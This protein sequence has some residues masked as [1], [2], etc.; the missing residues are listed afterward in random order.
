[1]ARSRSRG[2]TLIELLV[3]IAIIAVLIGLLLPA[4]QKVREAASRAKCSNNLKQMGLAVHH[5]HDV[6]G[7]LP[8][9]DLGDNWPTWA[10]L[11]MPHLEQENV[12]RNWNLGARYYNQVPEAGADLA[13]Y[14]CPSRS[15]PG[16]AAAGG[17]AGETRAVGT[18][19]RTGPIG[20][21]DYA[22]S[23]GATNGGGVATN[24][25]GAGYRAFYLDRSAYL[26][27]SQ[28][29]MFEV[30][31]GWRYVLKFRDVTDGLSGTYLIGE[32]FYLRTSNGGVI[33]NGDYQSQ[34][35]RWA[36]RE[37]TQDPATGRW[38]TERGLV[39]DRDYAASDWNVRFSAANHLGV[40][41]FVFLDG[42]VAPVRAAADLE[43]VHRQAK[44]N[45]G[46]VTPNP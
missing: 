6:H 14:H 9:C 44:R 5:F 41:M 38:T 1:M 26:N 40:G 33:Y 8:A 28:T 30:W 36:G 3:V 43:V 19:T 29:D 21:G 37:G 20:W 22:M 10:V 46:L 27:S 4:V 25:D 11:L 12:Y 45:D 7:A 34:Y 24:W 13:V 18:V 32:K 35:L 16:A 23:A 31:P 42:S 17:A 2:F 39:T 15:T